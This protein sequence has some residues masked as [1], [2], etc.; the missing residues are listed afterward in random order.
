MT[1]QLPQQQPNNGGL[2]RQHLAQQQTVPYRAITLPPAPEPVT[3]SFSP[4]P[5][6]PSLAQAS[7]VLPEQVVEDASHKKKLSITRTVALVLAA[8]LGLSIYFIWHS[9]TPAASTP[10][11]TQ[12]QFNPVS[13]ALKSQTPTGASP[14]ATNGTIQVYIVGAVKHPG[15]YTLAGNARLYQLLKA[16]GGPLPNANMILLNLAAHL[17]DGQE[18]YVTQIGETPPAL[19]AVTG[20]TTATGSASG[21][22]TGTEPVTAGQ[23]ININTA[24]ADELR[25]A[26]HISS[27]TAQAIITY[28]VQQGPFTSVEQLS[29]IVSKAIYNKI[30]GQVTIA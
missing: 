13:P 7:E 16:A 10:A 24:S 22:T 25:Q 15:V 3:L 18:I 30:K 1:A 29:Q 6:G 11:V 5:T 23:Q 21:T 4:I 19:S 12:Q 9:S 28:R 17:V 2:I 8:I 27:K 20:T 26:L 14:V